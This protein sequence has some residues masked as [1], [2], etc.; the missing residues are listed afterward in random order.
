MWTTSLHFCIHAVEALFI[1]LLS[2]HFIVSQRSVFPKK[3][4][5]KAWF[6]F[7]VALAMKELKMKFAQVWQLC[8]STG[9]HS[10]VLITGHLA[11]RCSNLFV[12]TKARYSWIQQL[13]IELMLAGLCS[14]CCGHGGVQTHET[15]HKWEENTL[16][17]ALVF[18]RLGFRESLIYIYIYIY[19]LPSY[20]FT[21]Y[22]I[23]L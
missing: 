9:C 7:I 19:I 10:S 17:F 5:A 2:V 15:A 6:V 21:F 22:F 18:E 12:G 8:W 13:F 14:R 1:L 4:E 11:L 3:A 16:T 23:I 20:L